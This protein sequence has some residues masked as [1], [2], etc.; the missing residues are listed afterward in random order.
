MNAEKMPR[1]KA[2]SSAPVFSESPASESPLT[3]AQVSLSKVTALS[4]SAGAQRLSEIRTVYHPL[5]ADDP[6]S[7]VQELR[8]E[9]NLR[10]APE[11][12]WSGKLPSPWLQRPSKTLR[13][14]ILHKKHSVAPVL[15]GEV[16]M[17]GHSPGALPFWD[18]Q[19]PPAELV[20]VASALGSDVLFSFK[21]HAL[22][23]AGREVYPYR[24]SLRDTG[25]DL[26]GVRFH[27]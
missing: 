27:C 3:V 26:P 22:E 21:G 20:S 25:R 4:I 11:A 17:R 16:G 23:S 10:V 6:N 14:H 9:A 2:R 15:A 13:P 24:T 19:V 1:A 8:L 18:L 5:V 12:T 7:P